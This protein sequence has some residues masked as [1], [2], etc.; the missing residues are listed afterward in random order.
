[1]AQTSE[2]MLQ[3]VDALKNKGGVDLGS[4]K[5]QATLNGAII[6][7]AGGAFF[8]YARKHNILVMGLVGALAG[9]IV[10]RIFTPQ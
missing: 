3:R 5:N 1:M 2:Q 7:F 10:S 8:G 6:G 4:E 9:A